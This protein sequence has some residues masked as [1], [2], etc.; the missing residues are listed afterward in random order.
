M[1]LFGHLGKE[2]SGQQLNKICVAAQS[3]VELS[4]L[5]CVKWHEAE[6]RFHGPETNPAQRVIPDSLPKNDTSTDV[7]SDKFQHAD[8][9][10]TL[11]ESPSPTP[12]EA[13]PDGGL[14]QHPIHDDD[15]E[16]RDSEDYE[17][18]CRSNR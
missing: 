18:R 6:G 9:L 5:N 15:L 13:A 12:E 11:S 8:Q 16:D 2:I 10:K 17:A 14:A 3:P 4:G 1:F 7:P